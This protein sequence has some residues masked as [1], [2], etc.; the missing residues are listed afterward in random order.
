MKL[1]LT[2][3]S[4]ALKSVLNKKKVVV[5]CYVIS[6]IIAF[7]ASGPL[8]NF[9]SLLLEQSYTLEELL[10]GFDYDVVMEIVNYNGISLRMSIGAILS[11]FILYILWSNFSAG[12]FLY[13]E[14]HKTNTLS[15]FWKGGAYYFFRFIRLSIYQIIML[16]ISLA[17][18]YLYFSKDGLNV[19]EMDSEVFLIGRFYFLL[20]ILS[21]IVFITTIFRD[22][23]RCH[24]ASRDEAIIFR[25]NLKAFK[26]TWKV[27]PILLAL[28]N[29][30]VL[31]IVLFIYQI[32]KSA[33]NPYAGFLLIFTQVYLL[34]RIYFRAVRTLSFSHLKI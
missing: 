1:I 21:L 18:A 26:S 11:G 28:L 3:Y 22:L 12:G 25:S 9:L 13:L 16:L 31:G 23:A 15:D 20:V 8:S 17:L 27:K 4:E 5:L 2:T 14:K 10:M 7:I 6:L 29:V 30:L 24:I 34:L 33:F 32:S 19:L